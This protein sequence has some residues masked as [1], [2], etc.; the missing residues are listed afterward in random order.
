MESENMSK[1]VL[2]T[3]ANGFLGTQVVLRLLRSYN[4]KIIALV[5]GKD[6]QHAVNRLFRAWWEFTELLD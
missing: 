6:K 2:L 3:G 4:Y 1:V 5:R